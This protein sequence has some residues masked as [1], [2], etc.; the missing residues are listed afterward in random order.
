MRRPSGVRNPDQREATSLEK[1]TPSPYYAYGLDAHIRHRLRAI[2]LKHWKRKR[3]IAK[4]LI[5]RGIRHKTAWGNV[6][7]GRRSWWKLSHTP[8][9]DRAL[10]NAYFADQGLV[11]LTKK[12][13]EYRARTIALAPRQLCL[14]LG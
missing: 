7:K 4:R 3:T 10:P 1:R 13:E 12:W 2:I 5:K 8:A 9:V 6:Y 14:P 11:F